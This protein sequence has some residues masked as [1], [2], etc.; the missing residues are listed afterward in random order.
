MAAFGVLFFGTGTASADA[1]ARPS[2][3]SVTRTLTFGTEGLTTVPGYQIVVNGVSEN[4]DRIHIRNNGRNREANGTWMGNRLNEFRTT[5]TVYIERQAF[6]RT[7]VQHFSVRALDVQDASAWVYCGSVNFSSTEVLGASWCTTN[8]TGTGARVDWA[9]SDVG[10]DNAT[11]VVIY[12]QRNGAGPWYWTGRT[13][14]GSVYDA[15]INWNEPNGRWSQDNLRSGNYRYRVEMI[16]V[17]TGKRSPI[18]P[19]CGGPFWGTFGDGV[20]RVS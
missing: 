17:N 16:N 19:T 9:R 3:C 18:S 5:S 20:A 6:G 4:A 7:G 10:P 13:P 1:P 14:V 15:S 8:G 2:S 12:R 11:H